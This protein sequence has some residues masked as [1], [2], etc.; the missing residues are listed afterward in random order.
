MKQKKSIFSVRGRAEPLSYSYQI[1]CRWVLISRGREMSTFCI[2]CTAV[3]SLSTRA[4]RVPR[5][6]SQITAE[7]FQGRIHRR[8][9]G[10]HGPPGGREVP[11]LK[12]PIILSNNENRKLTKPPSGAAQPIPRRL[13]AILVTPYPPGSIPGSWRL[14]WGPNNPSLSTQ[15][16]QVITPQPQQLPY[17]C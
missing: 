11:Q 6:G 5:E 15:H 4:T 7:D 3:Q 8:G 2:G 13:S 17:P 14:S 1:N 9:Q 12:I 10:G 16:P